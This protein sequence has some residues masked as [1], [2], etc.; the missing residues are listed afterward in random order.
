MTT[1]EVEQKVEGTG[2]EPAHSHPKVV[3]SHDHYHISHHHRSGVES[4]LGEWEHRSSWHTHEHNHSVL[5]H[6]HDYKH[7]DEDAHHGSEA[8]I[9]SHDSPTRGLL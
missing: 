8:H 3:H 1:Q 9:H 6:G 2:H 4:A 5:I 7:G